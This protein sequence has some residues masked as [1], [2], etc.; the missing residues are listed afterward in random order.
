MVIQYGN[1]FDLFFIVSKL[2]LIS[3]KFIKAVIY[4][5]FEKH[6]LSNSIEQ[7]LCFTSRNKTSLKIIK[8]RI[9]NVG[10]Y[11]LLNRM[12]GDTIIFTMKMV[13]HLAK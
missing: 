11:R 3:I 13:T 5:Q 4:Y 7:K 10:R 9:I 2:G 1:K 12:K 6:V 8:V